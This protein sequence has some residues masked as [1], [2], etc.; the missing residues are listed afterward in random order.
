MHILK[1]GKTF[2]TL[3][4]SYCYVICAKDVFKREQTDLPYFQNDSRIRLIKFPDQSEIIYLN[5]SKSSD[6]ELGM[7]IRTSILK[8]R[9]R[10][11]P[12]FL[13]KESLI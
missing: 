6:N 12:R 5:A 9:R 4:E 13:Q 7:L 8:I 11:I 1:K 10:C 3:P 2:E